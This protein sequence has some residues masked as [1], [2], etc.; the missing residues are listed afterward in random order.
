MSTQNCSGQ[1]VNMHRIFLEW[2]SL[3]NCQMNALHISTLIT[4][5]DKCVLRMELWQFTSGGKSNGSL[6]P[7]SYWFCESCKIFTS[8]TPSGLTPRLIIPVNLASGLDTCYTMSEFIKKLRARDTF[9][10]DF[11]FLCSAIQVTV[12]HN[13]SVKKGAH[14]DSSQGFPSK[15][16]CKAERLGPSKHIFKDNVGLFPT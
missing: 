15:A 4:V 7:Q 14:V 10:K 1:W 5:F 3:K 8:I 9:S 2:A 13:T 6:R 11:L 16:I 12:I